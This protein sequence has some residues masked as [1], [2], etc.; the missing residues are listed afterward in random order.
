MLVIVLMEGT[1]A[2]SGPVAVNTFPGT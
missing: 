1:S 2:A